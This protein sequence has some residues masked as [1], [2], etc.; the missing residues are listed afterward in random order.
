MVSV[1]ISNDLKASVQRNNL[2]LDL[3]LQN[4]VFQKMNCQPQSKGRA[5]GLIPDQ[6]HANLAL[7]DLQYFPVDISLKKPYVLLETFYCFRATLGRSEKEGCFF[8]RVICPRGGKSRDDV[9]NLE[10]I[11]SRLAKKINTQKR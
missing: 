2:A 9:V 10:T 6:P 7:K 1:Q 3:L 4:P 11:S 8:W 5:I